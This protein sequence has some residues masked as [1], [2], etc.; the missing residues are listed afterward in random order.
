KREWRKT[1]L[2]VDG[3]AVVRELLR[4]W[5]SGWNYRVNLAS[6]ATEALEQMLAAPASIV[7]VDI[8]LPDHDG[9]WLMEHIHRKWPTT[10]FILATGAADLEAVTPAKRLGAVDYVL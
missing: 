2:I 8:D 10:Q 9:F 5:F 3:D 6:C 4:R 1:I 7:P